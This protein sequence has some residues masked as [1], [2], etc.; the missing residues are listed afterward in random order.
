M[1]DGFLSGPAARLYARLSATPAGLPDDADLPADA[2][3]ELQ[4]LGLVLR[5]PGPD[6]RVAAVPVPDAFDRLLRL[7]E[8]RIRAEL[9]RLGEQLARLDV[10]W[11]AGPASSITAI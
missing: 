9:T 1:F 11:T 8:L 10:A 4:Q 6:S 2:V 5:T 7:S 3:A